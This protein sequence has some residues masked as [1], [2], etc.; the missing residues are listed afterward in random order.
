MIEFEVILKNGRAFVYA[1]SWSEQNGI[2]Y[3]WEGSAI[4]KSFSNSVSVKAAQ[5]PLHP[6]GGTV[7]QNSREEQTPSG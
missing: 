4:V 5:H 3:F 6:T 7:E 2:V 1:D